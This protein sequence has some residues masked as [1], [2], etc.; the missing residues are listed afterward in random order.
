MLD[1]VNQGKV[2]PVLKRIAE[3][4][5]G[6][7]ADTILLDEE[8]W[9][10]PSLLPGWTRAHVA[11]H[12]ARNADALRVLMSA[13]STGDPHALYASDNA[14][15]NDIE[16]GA[17]RTGMD[18]HVD[19]DTSAGELA[20]YSAQVED[21]LIPVKVFGGE[22]PL[23]VTP[24]IRLSELSLHHVDLDVGY[25]WQDVEIV[26]ARWLL[27]WTLLL[28]DDP[29]L[30]A[31]ELASDSGVTGAMGEGERRSVSG[32]DAA[33]WAWLTGRSSG[34]GL[35]GAEGLVFPLAG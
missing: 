25:S 21:W 10:E 3:A 35:T 13:A 19:L 4:T 17:E 14:K 28:M 8:Q 11:T 30:P 20:R 34:E 6:I 1:I 2:E 18:L 32:S 27:Q 7:L 16:R 26:P 12:L 29:A 33:L 31:V 15:F 23:S 22:F 9:R 24:L 5:Q